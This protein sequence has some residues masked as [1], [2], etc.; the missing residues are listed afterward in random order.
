MI[1]LIHEISQP[2]YVSL[3]LVPPCILPPLDI[4][5]AL[6]GSGS[7]GSTNF[8]NLLNFVSDV[9]SQYDIDRETGTQVSVVT[10]ASGAA[11]NITLPQFQTKTSLSSA[12][13]SIPYP[14]GGTSTH[15]GIQAARN[16]F[17]VNGRSGAR[18]LLIVATDGRSNNPADTA[19]QAELAKSENIEVF[20]IGIGSGANRDELRLIA[21]DPDSTYVLTITNY[22]AESFAA[23]TEQLNEGICTS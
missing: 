2:N 15:L 9:S 11:T 16:E 22:T 17:R 3:P 14:G 7:V 13:V 4:V 10:F 23:I 12:I 8:T 20:A 6:D 5:F 18:R 1:V 19:A 21:T